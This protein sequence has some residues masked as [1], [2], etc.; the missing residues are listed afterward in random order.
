MLHPTRF[1]GSGIAMNHLI[2]MGSRNHYPLP[3]MRSSS[4]PEQRMT[5]VVMIMKDERHRHRIAP[6]P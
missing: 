6:S 2:P 3:S 4:I 1:T 5:M